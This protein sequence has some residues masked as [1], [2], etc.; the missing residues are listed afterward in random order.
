MSL[1][2]G[3][4]IQ[5]EWVLRSRTPTAAPQRGQLVPAL[6]LV[7]RQF[8]QLQLPEPDGIANLALRLP[9]AGTRWAYHVWLVE[10]ESRR[11]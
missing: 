3:C 7:I 8:G 1:I 9:V 6:S 10:P 2:S 5:P 11:T 4:L